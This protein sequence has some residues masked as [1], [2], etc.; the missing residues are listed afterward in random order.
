MPSIRAC[1]WLILLVLALDGV[2]LAVGQ[3]S[4]NPPPPVFFGAVALGAFAALP[5]WNRASA[6]SAAAA[7]AAVE[8][9][10]ASFAVALFTHL[11]MAA[12]RP[13]IDGVLADLDF[14]LGFDWRATTSL[15]LTIDPRGVL[16]V[17]YLAILPLVPL[18]PAILHL[19]G[20]SAA[21]EAYRRVYMLS[22][23]ACGA[24]WAFFF[25]QGPYFHLR[26]LGI[27]V[28]GPTIVGAEAYRIA[29]LWRAGDLS[30]VDVTRFAGLIGF[31]S[32]HA[33]MAILIC[34]G[35]C[36]LKAGV[37][38][39]L[40]LTVLVLVATVTEGGHNVVDVIAGAGLTLTLL[41]A[42]EGRF[43]VR[44]PAARASAARGRA[45]PGIPA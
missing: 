19:L 7:V 38:V 20:K 41:A 37:L 31:P 16:A 44:R 15:M 17:I 43:T 35:L 9:L 3:V 34:Y 33:A 26:E 5:L 1:H 22:L 14:L 13:D 23:L 40:P 28:P 10:T 6:R 21:A 29:A 11:W 12:P 36:Q 8:C 25:S 32:F 39:A 18:I 2:L 42:C 24:I 27:P 30:Q 45:G 4:V